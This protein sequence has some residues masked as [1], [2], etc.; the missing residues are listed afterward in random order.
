[1]LCDKT[2]VE[3]WKAELLR[4]L[5]RNRDDYAVIEVD[6]HHYEALDVRTDRGRRSTHSQSSNDRSSSRVL[7]WIA[8]I[9]ACARVV[10]L[11]GTPIVHRADVELR[12]FQAL[13]RAD[14]TPL[15]GRVSHFSQKATRDYARRITR[16]SRPRDQIGSEQPRSDSRRPQEQAQHPPRHR[17]APQARSVWTAPLAR[18]SLHSSLRP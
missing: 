1:M 6:V 8:Q 9:H 12:A 18:G 7:A 3:Q 10:F 14:A 11:S 4:V 17:G 16:R 5:G 15:E 2:I 13:M